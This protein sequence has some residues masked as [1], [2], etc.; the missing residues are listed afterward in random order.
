MSPRKRIFI[1]VQG[2]S[3]TGH[4]NRMFEVARAL[5]PRHDVVLLEGGRA[6]PRPPAPVARL[7]LPGLLR[8]A[9]GQ[10]ASVDG[11]PVAEVL[12]ERR[13]SLGRAIER[14]RPDIVL[15]EDFPFSKW[16]MADEIRF[17]IA[18]ARETNPGVHVVSCLRD[19]GTRNRRPSDVADHPARV[20]ST[21]LEDFDLVLVHADPEI[22]RIDEHLPWAAEIET[23]IRYTGFVSQ[24]LEG[25][26]AA[27]A[28]A[29]DREGA[30]R[31]RVVVSSGGA[32]ASAL[33]PLAVEAWK[34]VAVSLGGQRSKQMTV[35]LPAYAAAEDSAR[36]R[37]VV[38]DP[39][40]SF[41]PFSPDFLPCLS[42]ADVSVSHAGYNTCTNVLETRT[43]AVLVPNAG[44]SDQPLRARLL[45]R[46]GL[47]EVLEIA[48]A[49]PERLAAAILRR[50]EAKPPPHGIDLAGAERARR[51]L[52][53]L[54]EAR[55]GAARA[56]V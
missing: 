33:I 24:K 55:P 13:A 32:A 45:A 48:S 39:S 36:W 54:G 2:L 34:H 22:V 1:Y 44:M 47:A 52:E 21:L 10:L 9:E 17:V 30:E 50:S 41:S 4:F 31:F 14:M 29:S 6:V 42:R 38:A 46:L 5:A 37:R 16:E 23:P 56:S 35:F 18:R 8:G 7:V 51:I 3:G 49:T 26:P 15:V 28:D 12:G 20:R 53:E 27:V 19:I 43:P 40:I 11:R 25:R